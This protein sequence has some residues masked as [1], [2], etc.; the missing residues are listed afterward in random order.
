MATRHLLRTLALLVFV[1]GCGGGDEGGTEVVQGALDTPPAPS[2]T[3]TPVEPAVGADSAAVPATEATPPATTPSGATPSTEVAE[4]DAGADSSASLN[5]NKDAFS[6]AQVV[7]EVFSYTGGSRDPFVSLLEISRVGP[8][9]PDLSL[10][11]I[12]YDTR[13]PSN[14]VVVMREKVSSKRHNLRQG[15]RIGRIRVA[16]IRPK[17]VTFTI[18]DFGTDRQET[19]TLRKQEDTP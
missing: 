16:S 13:S 2:P 10:V 4:V 11:A 5:A 6:D 19:L 3:S 9:L 14:S 15:D 17:D 12:Y 7:R 18:D 1:A 8:E